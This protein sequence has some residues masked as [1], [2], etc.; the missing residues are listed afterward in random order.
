[1]ASGLWADRL[2]DEVARQVLE[3]TARKATQN[4]EPT[5]AEEVFKHVFE[6]AA[7]AANSNQREAWGNYAALAGKTRQQ[8]PSART[9]MAAKVCQIGGQKEEDLSKEEARE[10]VRQRVLDITQAFA[11]GAAGQRRR[12]RGPRH[13]RR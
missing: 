3:G 8:W 2:V 6:V 4:V 13:A 5:S 9:N 10:K 1:M 7:D 11:Q 12:Q